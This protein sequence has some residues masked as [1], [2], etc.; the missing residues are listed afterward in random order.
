M[1]T[2]HVDTLPNGIKSLTI[3]G[4]V[5]KSDDELFRTLSSLSKNTQDLFLNLSAMEDSEQEF[6]D[7]L[8]EI[9]PRLRLRVITKYPAVMEKCSKLGLQVFPSEKSAQ[10]AMTGD[11]TVKAVLS[12]LREVPILNTDAYK[13]MTYIG[14]P[15]ANMDELEKMIKENPGLVSQILKMANSAMYYRGTKIESLSP[16]MATLGAN[17]LRMLFLFNFYHGVTNIFGA[18]KEVIDHG[19]QCALLSEFIAKSAK[20]PREEHPKVWLSGLLHDIGQQALAFVFPEKYQLVRKYVEEEKKP[21]YFGELL[22]FGIDHQAV[23]RQLAIKWN[24]PEY[25]VNVIGDHHSLKA[26]GWNRLT[27]PVFCANNYL[28][29][30]V[31]LPFVSY[32]SKLVGYFMLYKAEVTWAESPGEEFE[33]ALEGE[34]PLF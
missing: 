33:K 21:S 9:S 3:E 12:R 13:L 31:G 10:L 29:E 22:T 27:L 28:N 11:N 23:G 32:Y 1:P 20:A 7:Y 5:Q 2:Y 14:N 15:N 6:F 17:N 25:L 24:F 26:I 16:A 18:Q 19:K 8:S 4:S 34:H 30:R